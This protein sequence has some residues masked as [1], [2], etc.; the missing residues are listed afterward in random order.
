VATRTIPTDAPE[1]DG[2]LSWDATTIVLVQL[3]AGGHT[4]LGWTYADAAAGAVIEGKLADTV[5]GLDLDDV[6]AAWLAMRRAVRNDGE[7]GLAACAISAVDVALWDRQARARGVPL[8]TALGAFRDVVPAYGSGGFC[9]YDDA[10]LTAQLGDWAAEG[11][12]A[13][14]MKVGRE[15]DA[16]P[17]RVR[18]AR[19][20]IGPDVKLYVDANGAWDARESVRRAWELDDAAGGIR[21]LEEPVSSRNRDG[22]RFVREH[23]PPAAAVAA[24][25][26][27]W[28]P[29]DALE[30][31]TARAVDVLQA[32]AT[33]CCGLTGFRAI[34][35]L[36]AAHGV[37]LSAHCSPALH[38]HASCAAE[39]MAPLEYFHDHV[40]IEAALFDD[41]P[42]PAGGRLRVDRT[43]AGHGLTLRDT[44]RFS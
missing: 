25:E 18:V 8:A 39:R 5:D 30:L 41:V 24:G 19:A 28:G 36:V 14:K 3:A 33:R 27:V 10:R 16:D 11:F 21:W 31:L 15:P 34:A 13:V 44:V 7:T 9:S 4:G 43:R 32:D 20:A 17:H 22:L 23:G 40:R 6:P 26:Y 12:R 2:T 38:L 37:S 1:S 35:A 29:E 42:V